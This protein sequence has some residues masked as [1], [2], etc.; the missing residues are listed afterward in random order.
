MSMKEYY[1]MLFW[2]ALVLFAVSVFAEDRK[3]VAIVDTGYSPIY[4][5][6]LCQGYP[7]IDVTGTGPY[8]HHGHG[9]NVAGL[10]LKGL[11]PKKHCLVF[12]KLYDPSAVDLKLM[13]VEELVNIK[14]DYVNMSFEGNG[15]SVKEYRG[16]KY[17]ADRGTKLIVAA[18]NE[19]IDLGKSC[20]IYPACHNIINNFYV[21]GTTD[22]Y[23]N[24]GGP[25]KYKAQGTNQC[26][27][28]PCLTG[29]SQ[30]TANFTA[31][32]LRSK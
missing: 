3:I 10:I 13:Y 19:A 29:T 24:Y 32:L 26:A 25:V 2:V 28:G 12:I 5:K 27:G 18:G 23:S 21:V 8:D 16:L 1:K 15:Y 30:A 4:E 9:T 31:N 6:Y 14:P 22:Y 7:L 17:L 20:R 11:N